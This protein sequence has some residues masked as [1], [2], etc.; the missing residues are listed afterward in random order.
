M[1]L[2]GLLFH[3][4][5][6]YPS[7]SLDFNEAEGFAFSMGQCS[8]SAKPVV[9]AKVECHSVNEAMCNKRMKPRAINVFASVNTSIF[10]DTLTPKGKVSHCFPWPIWEAF[11]FTLTQQ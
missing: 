7:L 10:G 9:E 11:L 6:S 1:A 4:S 3:D 5:T 2:I 8:P